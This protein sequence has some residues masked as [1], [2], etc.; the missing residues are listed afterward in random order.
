MN[1][2][3]FG[4]P[5][6]VVR[7]KD[8]SIVTADD[9]AGHRR[10]VYLKVR[11]S[12]PVTLMEAFDTPRMEINCVR[13][14]EAT[15]PTQAL[16]MFNS[17][18]MERAAKSL[19]ERITKTVTDRHER[20]DLAWNLLYARSPNATERDQVANFLDAFVSLQKSESGAATT[21]DA[22]AAE[23]AAWPHLALT[24]LNTNEF[25]YVD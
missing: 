11:R 13:R 23:T 15:V 20:I 19:A 14:T 8:G 10:S 21:V 5:V 25:L 9:A 4:P 16:A 1:V 18:F 17:P 22:L 12:Q 6:Q 7:E 2:D 3:P 24:L